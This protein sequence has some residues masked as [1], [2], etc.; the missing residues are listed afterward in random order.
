MQV[1]RAFCACMTSPAH[2]ART[3]YIYEYYYANVLNYVHT[4]ADCLC[5][6]VSL[7]YRS[8]KLM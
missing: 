4:Y 7:L 8:I 2:A 5:F 1:P 3:C 6:L